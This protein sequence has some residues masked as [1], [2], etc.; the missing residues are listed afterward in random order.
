MR[1][2]LANRSTSKRVLAGD[3][4]QQFKTSEALRQKGVIVETAEGSLP[5]LQHVDLVHLFNIIPV[6]ETYRLFL[7]AKKAS[8]PVVLS[9]IYWEPDEFLNH[10]YANHGSSFREWWEK[11]NEQR[12]ILLREAKMI[13]PNGEGELR[14][15]KEKFG[16]IAPAMIIPNAADPLF[17]LAQPE[18]FRRK[19]GNGRFILSVGRI[20]RRKNQLSLIRALSRYDYHIVFIGP[21]NDFDYYRE[22]KMEPTRCRVSFIEALPPLELASAYAAADL[23][24]LPSWYETPG[25]VSLEAALAGAKV[26]S[27]NR[28]TAYE[29]F[30]QEAWYC[31]PLDPATIRSAIDEALIHPGY[32]EL[33]ERIRVQYNWD[34]VAELTLAAYQQVLDN[35]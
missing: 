35:L 16:D 20:S 31:D 13:L 15:L 22:C 8:I 6:E 11:T 1:V 25:L 28:G 26:V 2:V 34:K 5:S 7:E 21:V 30:G 12:R 10:A 14:L 3:A 9:P 29:Y 17:Y 24:A 23:H 4:V 19:F 33:R 18:R 27:T 32:R